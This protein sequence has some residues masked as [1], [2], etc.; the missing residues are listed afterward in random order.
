MSCERDYY[1]N[2]LAETLKRLETAPGDLQWKWRTQKGLPNDPIQIDAALLDAF[3]NMGG[4]TAWSGD[5]S[6]CATQIVQNIIEERDRYWKA[7]IWLKETLP[8]ENSYMSDGHNWKLGEAHQFLTEIL[9]IVPPSEI[10]Q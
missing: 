3:V 7:L 2:Q 1:L 5:G 10:R 8:H 6:S 9:P 4:A